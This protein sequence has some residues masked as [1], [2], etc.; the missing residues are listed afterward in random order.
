MS[1]ETHR[2]LLK[3]Q[4]P[5][6]QEIRHA[7]GFQQ[8]IPDSL[9]QLIEHFE[10]RVPLIGTFSC[11][12]S[13]LLNALLGEKLLSTEI[14]PETAISAELRHAPVRQVSGH[15]PDGRQFALETA[16]PSE[17]ELAPLLKD[18]E[19]LGWLE[20]GIPNDTLARYP[21]LVLVDLPGWDS[22]IDAH[23]NVI[24]NYA[25]RSLAYV[26]V[27]SVEEGSLRA[28]LRK[29]LLELAV[30]QMPVI[31]VASKADKKTPEDVVAVV[32]RLRADITATMGHPPIAVA[33]TSSR[34]K[35][36]DQLETG[37]AILQQ[38]AD[39]IFQLR[40]VDHFMQELQHTAQ[41]LSLLA[42]KDD[43]DAALLQAEIEKLQQDIQTFDTRLQL[44]TENLEGQIGPILAAI[45]QR[46]E[47]KLSERI[48]MLAQYVV[49][50][51]N[52]SDDILGTARLVIAET[53]RDEFEPAMKRYLE[54]LVDALPSRLDFNLDFKPL[55]TTGESAQQGEFRWKALSVTLAPLLL[56][57]PH[58]AAKVAA[59]LLPILSFFLDSQADEQRREVEEARQ[60]ERARLAVRSKLTE[61]VRVIEAQ[62]RSAL[63]EQIEKAKTEVSRSI[64][65]ERNE[66]THTLQTKIKALNEGEAEMARL[67]AAAQ[68]DLDRIQAMRAEL[69]A[70]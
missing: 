17:N 52:I 22:G 62:L 61:A 41:L 63:V 6:L 31:L 13:S 12:K 4:L 64:E 53:L 28:S 66:V 65:A 49:N 70:A 42:N 24:D 29:A 58:P 11:G 57:I 16:Q 38:K 48:D 44:E 26:V 55:E 54:R 5:V 9:I 43:Q 21:Q 10:I 1:F 3:K 59:A 19:N 37:L 56:K 33:V 50:G 32:E 51:H 18:K 60:L 45:R 35:E 47:N 46:V 20:I 7:H 8:A 27:V 23:N 15:L 39:D 67:R 36:L 69:S 40:V 14:T 34:K 30:Q 25:H 68:A 2:L